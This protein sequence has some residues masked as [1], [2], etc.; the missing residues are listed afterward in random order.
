[1]WPCCRHKLSAQPTIVLNMRVVPRVLVQAIRQNWVTSAGAIC[2]QAEKAR[3]WPPC[4]ACQH[5]HSVSCTW[6]HGDYRPGLP[7]ERGCRCSHAPEA[8][9]AA[10]TSLLSCLGRWIDGPLLFVKRSKPVQL[11]SDD[12]LCIRRSC[13]VHRIISSLPRFLTATRIAAQLL[14]LRAESWM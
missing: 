3:Y 10:S 9:V 7:R 1:M 6:L 13:V 11:F 2:I 5:I 4:G 14:Q 8:A 12:H